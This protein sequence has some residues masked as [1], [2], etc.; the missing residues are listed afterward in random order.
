M[1]WAEM[2]DDLMSL[3]L[4]GFRGVWFDKP[5]LITVTHKNF[6]GN[7]SSSCFL[8]AKLLSYAFLC[9][10]LKFLY[11]SKSATVISLAD[12][13]DSEN[14]HKDCFFIIDPLHKKF[15]GE[16]FSSSLEKFTANLRYCTDGDRDFS[17]KKTILG[18]YI[19]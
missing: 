17:V 12:R 2:E 11:Y 7:A 16:F 8:K 10:F 1:H 4:R 18:W 6:P 5:Y 15:T 14:L 9:K 3:D 13:V 19:F